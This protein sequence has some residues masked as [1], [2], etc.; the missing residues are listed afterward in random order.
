MAV[1]EDNALGEMGSGIM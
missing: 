1:D